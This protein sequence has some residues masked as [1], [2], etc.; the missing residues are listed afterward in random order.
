MD[1][2]DLLIQSLNTRI[3]GWFICI[4]KYQTVN[5]TYSF[6]PDRI[7]TTPAPERDLHGI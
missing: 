5:T 6:H 1:V 3:L 4:K 7:D 2:N